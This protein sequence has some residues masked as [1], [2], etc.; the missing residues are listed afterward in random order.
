[1]ARTGDNLINS[2]YCDMVMGVRGGRDNFSS[3]WI[4]AMIVDSQNRLHL[5]PIKKPIDDYFIAL[6]NK[7]E[8]IFRID[9][10]KILMWYA[11]LTKSFRVLWY[12]TAHYRPVSPQDYKELEIVITENSLPKMNRLQHTI[13]TQLARREKTKFEPHSLTELASE[14][15]KHPERNTERLLN[16][17]TYLEELDTKQIV[18]P[19][20]NITD[21]IQE[22]L[23]TTDPK[24]V[25]SVPESI[26]RAEEENR[27]V[28]NSPIGAKKSWIKPIG[29]LMAIGILVGIIVW[30]I[31]SGA[32]DSMGGGFGGISL[33]GFPGAPDTNSLIA[34]YPTPE[35]MRTA[36]DAGTLKESDLTPEMKKML[37]AYKPP[38]VDS[39]INV[40]P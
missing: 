30:G 23:I 8:Y 35:S 4:T 16:I 1:M 11:T 5:V 36:I 40:K 17:K 28:T 12:T 3:K 34:Q 20:R 14:I 24:F 27:R 19:V 21:F 33:P 10:S 18:T 2:V 29:L 38:K 26:L 15:K 31:Q 6:I 9:N 25:A 32:F 22:D 39:I 37:D 7:E 13:L